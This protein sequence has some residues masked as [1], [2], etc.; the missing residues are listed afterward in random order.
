MNKENNPIYNIIVNV[1]GNPKKYNE[2]QQQG[3]WDCIHTCLTEN[4]DIPDGK[5]NLEISFSKGVFKCWKCEWS[6]YLRKLIKRYGS[7]LDL[8][9]YDSL[10]DYTN[11]NNG[12]DKKLIKQEQLY[13]PQELILFK[14]VI[15]KKD[16]SYKEAYN[17]LISRGL[18]DEIINEYNIGYCSKGKYENRIIFPSY[19]KHNKL[20]YFLARSYVGHK[21]KYKNPILPKM[22]VIINEIN[23]NWDSTIFL[24]EGMMDAMALYPIK[25]VIPLIG[26]TMSD[27][28][29]HILLKRAKGY[30]IVCLDGD[31]KK[32]TYQIY[33]KL[34]TTIQLKNKVRII[35]LPDNSDLS[36]IRKD[37]GKEGIIEILKTNRKLELSD[38]IENN[39]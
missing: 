12:Q 20:N 28:L 18:N 19:N 9:Q 34:H 31:A 25:N 15:N 33:K 3:Q 14:D 17:Y 11:D 5:G 29:Y 6:G 35:D 21:I 27:H 32:E 26:K 7:K 37:F 10:I 13:L 30:I 36:D 39:I 22:N 4:N 38:Y 23:I 24:T 2:T 16:L 1:L 8:K